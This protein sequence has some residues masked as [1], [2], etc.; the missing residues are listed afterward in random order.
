MLL[1]AN[2]IKNPTHLGGL[3]TS[4]IALAAYLRTLAPTVSF[5][6]CGEFIACSYILGVPHPPGAPLYLLLG[7]VFSLLPLAADIGWRVNLISALASA[8]TVLLTYLIILQ[9]IREFRRQD[10]GWPE[11]VAAVIGALAF[12]F[13]D[14]FWFNAVEAEV[15]ALSM[16]FT[17]V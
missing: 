14:S 11:V 6:D 13:S 3:I 1:L 10:H 2:F 15:Y 8:A 4:I 16:F 12:A 5:W 7:R 17:V 9:L